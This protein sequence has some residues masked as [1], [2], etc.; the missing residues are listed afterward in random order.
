MLDTFDELGIK[1]SEPETISKVL[2]ES[3][4]LPYAPATE[5]IE[6]ARGPLT[7]P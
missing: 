4:S 1:T 7:K 6:A 2:Y 3:G 5:L